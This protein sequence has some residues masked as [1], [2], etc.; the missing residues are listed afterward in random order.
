M[1]AAGSGGLGL[2]FANLEKFTGNNLDLVAWL[3]Q[4]DR[5]CVVANRTEDAVK[6][7]LLMLCVAGQAKAILENFEEEKGAVQP[8]SQ[9]KGVLEKCMIL[10][11]LEKKR[12]EHLK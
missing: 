9:L 3:R 6:G 11:R 2:L 7:Q 10:Q 5:C 1:A 12:C 4:F 8:F